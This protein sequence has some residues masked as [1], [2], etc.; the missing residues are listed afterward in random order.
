[1]EAVGATLA[2]I[3]AAS[4]TIAS[5]RD[6]ALCELL[7]QCGY[8][9]VRGASYTYELGIGARTLDE[10]DASIH[11]VQSQDTTSAAPLDSDTQRN[12]ADDSDRERLA[13]G[14]Q[15]NASHAGRYNDAV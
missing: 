13:A 9:S 15:G 10:Q 6:D 3:S 7:T 4:P 1:M 11:T 14:A 2:G 8:R 12:S 5:G